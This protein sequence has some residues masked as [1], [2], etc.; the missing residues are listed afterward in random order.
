[1]RTP[2]R[3]QTQDEVLWLPPRN[4]RRG[5]H[6][7]ASRRAATD[8]LAT[9]Y[10]GFMS[11]TRPC[12]C[13]AATVP[14]AYSDGC[15]CCTGCGLVLEDRVC[16][17]NHSNAAADR[18]N[19]ID[20]DG[21]TRVM[22]DPGTWNMHSIARHK[23]SAPYARW[24]HYAEYLKTLTNMCPR[25]LNDHLDQLMDAATRYI[26]RYVDRDPVRLGP[27]DIKAIIRSV[28]KDWVRKYGER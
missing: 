8:E 15:I 14:T 7:K 1:M 27:R 23:Q 3:R 25:I 5:R 26:E 13:D 28:N 17:P 11:R 21:S 20:C 19:G 12:G 6:T 16:M 2:V 22:H 10:D 4:D 24:H 9:L 18:G